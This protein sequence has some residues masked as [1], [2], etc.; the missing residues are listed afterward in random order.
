MNATESKE[1]HVWAASR[2]R[3][4]NCNN[5]NRDNNVKADLFGASPSPV[6]AGQF[7]GNVEHQTRIIHRNDDSPKVAPRTERDIAA[8]SVASFYDDENKEMDSDK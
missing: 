2:Q 6:S 7:L 1:I 8:M 3:N 5:S 4:K